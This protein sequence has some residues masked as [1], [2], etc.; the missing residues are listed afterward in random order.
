MVCVV[1]WVVSSVTS[2]VCVVISV[3]T[4]V[5]GVVKSVIPVV[6]SFVMSVVFPFVGVGLTSVV[7]AV[8]IKSAVISVVA[9]DVVMPIVLSVAGDVGVGDEVSFVLRSVVKE[10]DVTCVAIVSVADVTSA[11]LCVVIS[12]VCASVI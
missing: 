8:D 12:E 11:V 1:S 3:V 4:S 10:E 5:A 6:I 7:M 9:G 2:V